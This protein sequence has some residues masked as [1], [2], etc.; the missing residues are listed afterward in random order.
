MIPEPIDAAGLDDGA[1]DL[2]NRKEASA[3]LAAFGIRLKPAS[4]ARLWSV[5]AGGPPC[6]HVRAKPYY[7]R[8]L[9]RA[10]ALSQVSEL[11]T[12]APAAARG[13]RHG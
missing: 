8:G 13:R 7:P 1:N 2:L 4:L 9:L 3:F 6:R 12:G 5:G 10:W 11:R